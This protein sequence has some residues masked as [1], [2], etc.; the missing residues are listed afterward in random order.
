MYTVSDSRGRPQGRVVE[1][2]G[3]WFVRVA[4]GARL[5]LCG[6]DGEEEMGLMGGKGWCSG[7]TGRGGVW[8]EGERRMVEMDV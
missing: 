7:G 4:R 8:E 6:G 5:R 1:E 2:A 3:G